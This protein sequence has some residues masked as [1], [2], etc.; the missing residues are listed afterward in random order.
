MKAVRELMNA[1]VGDGVFPGG[2]LLVARDS[3]IVFWEAFGLARLSPKRVMKKDTVF[4]LASLT[5]PLAS[6]VSLI[7]LFGRGKVALDQTLG[8]TISDFSETD[9]RDVTIRQLASHTSGL[10]DYRPYYKALRH[11]APGEATAQLRILLTAEPLVDP[12]GAVAVYSDVGFMILQWVIETV[13]QTTLDRFVQAAVYDHLGLDRLFFNGA[14]LGVAKRHCSYAA[15]EACPWRKKILEG[16]VHD[17]NAYVLGGV[18]GHAGLFGSAEAVFR[19][20]DHLGM[21]HAGRI[22][23]NVFARKAVQTFFRR[24]SEVGTWALGFD[25]PSRPDSSSGRYFSD[26]SVGHLGFTGTSFWM[27]LDAGVIVILLTNRVHPSRAVDKI[28]AFRPVLHDAVMERVATGH[29][30]RETR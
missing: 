4:D 5:K 27:D 22:T 12:P 29:G 26:H 17:D 10:P 7:V 14:A 1:A 24:Q 16:E 15:T 19:L 28:K 18:A 21:V 11:L 23:S 13:S 2:V 6:A 20:L 25:T 3:R 30:F 9:K 8:E